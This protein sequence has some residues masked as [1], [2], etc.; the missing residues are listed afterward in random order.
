MKAGSVVVTR[1]L[2]AAVTRYALPYP[3]AGS[4]E[5]KCVDWAHSS[6]L[7]YGPPQASCFDGGTAECVTGKNS[8]AE[9]SET[10][11]PGVGNRT[12]QQCR[13]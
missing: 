8:C 4:L 3:V 6:I 13:F 1:E 12:V 10:A 9:P 2:E 5:L 7:V 11:C